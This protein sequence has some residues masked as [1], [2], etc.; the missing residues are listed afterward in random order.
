M[1]KAE[2]GLLKDAVKDLRDAIRGKVP[3]ENVID[4]VEENVSFIHRR[5][6]QA[7]WVIQGPLP[8]MPCPEPVEPGK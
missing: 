7:Q 3:I 8:P 5:V 1:T 2:M 6:R 4:R